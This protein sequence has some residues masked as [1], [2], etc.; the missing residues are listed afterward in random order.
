MKL[1]VHF[2]D[3]L[4]FVAKA[5]KASLNVLLHLRQDKVFSWLVLHLDLARHARYIDRS[6]LQELSTGEMSY[7]LQV[8]CVLQRLVR[9]SHRPVSRQ[10]LLV[11]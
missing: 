8:N 1:D 5:S 3:Q 2:C 6:V 9:W 7:I 4:V 11:T 10:Q